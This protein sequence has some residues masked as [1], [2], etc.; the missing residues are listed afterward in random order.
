MCVPE[1]A[2]PGGRE[3][4][5]RAGSQNRRDE[6]WD[7]RGAEDEQTNKV[8]EAKYSL[9]SAC[10]FGRALRIRSHNLITFPPSL[11]RKQ[12]SWA[13]RTA[14]R[15]WRSFWDLPE[16]VPLGGPSPW[17][18]SMEA[19]STAIFVCLSLGTPGDAQGLLLVL[20]S[21]IKNW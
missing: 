2:E 9:L 4:E 12:E 10:P 18:T 20:Y 21:G 11:Q 17:E 5:A 13:G 8:L 7:W 14:L 3:E 1:A 16:M 6:A 19:A 15:F